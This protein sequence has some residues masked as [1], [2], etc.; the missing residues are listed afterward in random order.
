VYI[1]PALDKA[2]FKSFDELVE[3][4]EGLRGEGGCPW[5]KEQTRESLRPYLLEETYEVLDAIDKDDLELIVEELG[6]LLLQVVFHS[7]IA[8]EDGEFDINEVITSIVNKLI[9][10]HPHVFGD[11]KATSESGALKSWEAS[12]REYKGI[13]TYT[14]TLIDIPEILPGLMRAYKV[15]QK[16]ALA[17]FD[18]DDIE[19]AFAKVYEETEEVKEVYKTGERAIIEGEIGDLLF[20]VINVSRFLKIQPELALRATTEKFIKRFS[21]IEKTA[22]Q[23]G[24]K[25]D[26]MSLQEMDKL[27]NEAKQQVL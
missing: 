3:L 26:K 1:P 27:W 23:S 4:M 13:D 8:K 6:D 16:A 21:Y 19:D 5:D 14:Q 11:V 9:V 15:Q 12:K 20:S 2:K 10:R 24:K 22:L 17:G 18:W 7:Q 25:L